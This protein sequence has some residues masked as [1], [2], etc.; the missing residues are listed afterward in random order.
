MYQKQN[1]EQQEMQSKSGKKSTAKSNKKNQ[2]LQEKQIQSSMHLDRRQLSSKRLSIP[3]LSLAARHSDLIRYA[4]KKVAEKGILVALDD[5]LDT[6]L[7]PEDIPKA[8]KTYLCGAELLQNPEIFKA[9]TVVKVGVSVATWTMRVT[10]QLSPH[11]RSMPI[12]K[13]LNEDEEVQKRTATTPRTV[14]EVQEASGKSTT[15][16]FVDPLIGS[17]DSKILIMESSGEPE[18]M[19]E[20]FKKNT[21]KMHTNH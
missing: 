5:V 12:I 1:Q 10:P 6:E 14:A 2:E 18:A 4:L 15:E 16:L 13:K 3:M 8:A 21:K 19:I 17:P 20:V 9:V 11:H 7:V